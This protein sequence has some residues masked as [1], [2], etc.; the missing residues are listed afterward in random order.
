MS[1]IIK[2][3]FCLSSM[4]YI[5]VNNFSVMLGGGGIFI[6]PIRNTV[7]KMSCSRT[8]HAA[9]DEIESETSCSQV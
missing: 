5:A 4:L 7:D 6:E 8:Q 1:Q 9:Q 2:F 3:G